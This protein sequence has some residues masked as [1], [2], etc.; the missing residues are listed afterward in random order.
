MRKIIF[1]AVLFVSYFGFSQGG[2]KMNVAKFVGE[3][4]TTERNS[5]DVPTGERWLIWNAT[6]EQFEHA[7][8]DDVWSALTGSGV[9]DGD[10]GDITVSGSGSTWGLNSNSVGLSQMKDNSITT[11]EIFD[12]EVNEADLNINNTGGGGDIL[13]YTGGLGFEWFSRGNWLKDADKGDITVS[14]NGGSYSIDAGVV[15]ETELN[16][17]VNA[18]LDLADTSIQPSDIIDDDTFATASSSTVPSSESVKAYVDAEISGSGAVPSDAGASNGDVL[19]TDGAGTYTWETPSGGGISDGDKGDITVG[20]SGTN[21]IINSGSVTG[22]MIVNGTIQGVDIQDGTITSA[23]YAP[24]S[25]TNTIIAN[26]AV[27]NEK[28]A[29]MV[30]NT[31]KGFIAGG[32]VNNDPMDLTASQVRTIINVED[33]AAADQTLSLGGTGNKDLTIEDGNTIDLTGVDGI[34]PD[35]VVG[36]I[37]GR[38]GTDVTSVMLQTQA[39]FDSDGAT[40]TGE[41]VFISDASPAEVVTSATIAMEGWKMYN[42]SSTDAAT[43]TLSDCDPGETLTVYINRASAPTLAGTGLTFNQLPNTTAFAAATDM[44]IIFEVSYDSTTI[45]YYYVER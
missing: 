20:G 33:G 1:I 44:M 22:T 43:I 32:N 7:G 24:G 17:S 27:T 8:S 41:V 38:T 34:D 5:L 12:G 42:D 11:I 3:L 9:L 13:T 31:I 36:T 40:S 23:E 26:N 21:W 19:T 30:D 18:S 2:P 25:V 10:K 35:N 16:G 28:L 15:T 45:D 4:T 29:N 14:S 39:Q 6:T 37:S